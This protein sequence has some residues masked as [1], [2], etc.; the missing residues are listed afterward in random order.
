MLDKGD[1]DNPEVRWALHGF[2]KFMESGGTVLPDLGGDDEVIETAKPVATPVRNTNADIQKKKRNQKQIA[3][4]VFQRNRLGDAA[5]PKDLY[6]TARQRVD[7]HL[8]GGGTREALI[9]IASQLAVDNKLTEAQAETLCNEIM[10]KRFD[11]LNNHN[12]IEQQLLSD[13]TQ[14]SKSIF[15]LWHQL[16]RKYEVGV[17]FPLSLAEGTAMASVSKSTFPQLI[18]TMKRMQILKRLDKGKRGVDSKTAATYRLLVSV[19]G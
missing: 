14:L 19:S 5:V 18:K 13:P 2:Y 10:L 11:K 6:A 3:S 15:Y 16:S 8:N 1:F 4:E 17:P 9:Q 7:Q 12:V